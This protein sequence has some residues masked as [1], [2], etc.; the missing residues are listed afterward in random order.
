[1][2]INK[3]R[4]SGVRR[5][6]SEDDARG[7]PR[8]SREKITYMLSFLQSMSRPD[9]L[10]GFPGWKPHR[11]KGQPK[12]VELWSLRVTANWRLVFRVDGDEI[13]DVDL[14]DYH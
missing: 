13:T 12:G 7:V 8:A 1:M 9:E 10:H 4:H 6:F 2:R 5:L 3:I 14:T 11:M